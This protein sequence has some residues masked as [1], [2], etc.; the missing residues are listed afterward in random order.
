MEES[1]GI[2]RDGKSLDFG[3]GVS[4]EFLLTMDSFK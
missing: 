2:Q 3:R 4:S 1:D